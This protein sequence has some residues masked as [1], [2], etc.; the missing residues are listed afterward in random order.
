[1]LLASSSSLLTALARSLLLSNSN[2]EFD[3]VPLFFS[4]FNS[5][6]GKELTKWMRKLGTLKATP[7]N[8]LSMS[9]FERSAS[10]DQRTQIRCAASSH[11]LIPRKTL[12]SAACF[13]QQ[14]L[15][16]GKTFPIIGASLE[17]IITEKARSDQWLTMGAAINYFC[18]LTIHVKLSAC[19][20]RCSFPHSHDCR[21]RR[22]PRR[23]GA[24]IHRI[25]R[26]NH[27]GVLHAELLH[28]LLV[29]GARA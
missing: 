4:C 19:Q 5:L 8:F 25:A 6:N 2:H 24:D 3:G 13:A 11:S 14:R 9:G 26:E 18:T 10:R 7:C 17:A 22:R 21:P 29:S 12:M 16:I 27:Q 15:Q 20:K 1:M 23:V 28:L